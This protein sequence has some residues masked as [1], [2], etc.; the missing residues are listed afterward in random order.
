MGVICSH[1]IADTPCCHDEADHPRKF[2]EIS[3]P[4]K[5]VQELVVHGDH[6]L[7]RGAQAGQPDV[8]LTKQG[9]A[10]PSPTREDTT[11]HAP[12][13]AADDEQCVGQVQGE[14]LTGL[15]L[16]R[17]LGPQ[18]LRG[19][20]HQFQLSVLENNEHARRCFDEFARREEELCGEWAVFYHSYSCVALLY[21][22]Q[23]R[24]KDTFAKDQRDHHPDFR[25][26]A[27]SVMC[28][29]VSLGPEVSPP[30]CFIAG[31]S[32]S[33]DPVSYKTELQDLFSMLFKTP[34]KLVP[35]AEIAQLLAKTIALAEKY[36]LD[37]SHFGGRQRPSRKAGH[38]VQIFVRRDLVDEIA[39]AAAPW[40]EIDDEREPISE[41][42]DKDSN[43]NWGQARLVVRPKHFLRTSDVRVYVT[44]ADPD[45]HRKRS[46]FQQEL[47]E[48]IGALLARPEVRANARS[49]MVDGPV[50]QCTTKEP[51][52]HFLSKAYKRC[53]TVFSG[54]SG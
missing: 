47:V 17:K 48:L 35:D 32:H 29:L 39:Y 3:T 7:Y 26:V 22:V 50:R 41:W 11:Q 31:Y 14:V 28:S 23:E 45:F 52:R 18:S 5:L 46:D 1:T 27:I 15:A 43:T 49:A 6:E 38:L 54:N 19:N 37:V 53:S 25:R 42:L 13:V 51:K 8:Y 24:Y 16:Q 33:D 30:V 21:E 20:A 44:S 36:H 40:G 10:E 9:M 4:E 2:V 12:A 34:Q